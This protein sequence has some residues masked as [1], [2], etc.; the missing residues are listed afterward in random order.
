MRPAECAQVTVLGKDEL[1][2]SDAIADFCSRHDAAG[3]LRAYHEGRCS[4]RP[5]WREQA[6]VHVRRH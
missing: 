6:A 5:T 2:T 4:G 3:V 1:I